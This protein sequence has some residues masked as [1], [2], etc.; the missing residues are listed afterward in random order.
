MQQIRPISS[1]YRLDNDLGLLGPAVIVATVPAEQRVIRRL[2]QSV[3]D[4]CEARPPRPWGANRRNS[5]SR[6]ARHERPFPLAK[7]VN[8]FENVASC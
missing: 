1:E 3:R 5:T 8:Q 2:D 6:P 4:D 7:P